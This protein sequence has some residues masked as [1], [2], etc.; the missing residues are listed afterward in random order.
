MTR[1]DVK[2]PLRTPRNLSANYPQSRHELSKKISP[3]L[4]KAEKM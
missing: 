3:A 1:A 4:L 2:I